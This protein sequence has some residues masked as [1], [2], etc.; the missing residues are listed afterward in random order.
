MKKLFIL[1]LGIAILLP[2]FV[3][4]DHDNTHTIQQLT[5]QLKVLQEKINALAGQTPVPSFS[6]PA[7]PGTLGVVPKKAVIP[8]IFD[9]DISDDEIIQLNNLRIQSISGDTL[10]LVI[11]ASHEFGVRCLRF[12]SPQA[13]KGA[14]IPCPI[15]PSVIYNIQVDTDTVLLLRNRRRARISDFKVGDRI[16]VYGFMDRDTNAVEALII[17]NLDKPSVRQFI[18]LNNVE[19][20]KGPS[21][22]NP[23]ATLIVAQRHPIPCLDFGESG[24]GRGAPFPCPLG[25]GGGTSLAPGETSIKG[26]AFSFQRKYEVRVDEATRILQGN[27]TTMPLSEIEIGDILN[28]YGT[29]TTDAGVINA[30]V[31]RDLSKP[32]VNTGILRV[33]VTA[34]DLQCVQ[35]LGKKSVEGLLFPIQCGIL[36]DASVFVEKDGILVARGT[37]EKGFMVFEGLSPGRYLIRASA[38]GYQEGAGEALIKGGGVHELTIALDKIIDRKISIQTPSDLTGKVGEFF[39]ALFFAEGGASPYSWKITAG[40]LPSGLALAPSSLR[41]Q[42]SVRENMIAIQGTPTVPGSYKFELTAVDNIGNQGSAIFVSIITEVQANRPPVIHGISGPI[43][44]KVGETGTWSIKASDPENHPLNYSV[45]WGDEMA[46]ARAQ[47]APQTFGI[48]QEATFT[49]VYSKSGT[50]TPRFIVTDA[51]GSSAEAS[52]TVVVEE[53]T[54]PSITVL[55]PNGGE[56]WRKETTQLIQWKA[57]PSILFVDIFLWSPVPPGSAAPS[58]GVFIATNV[59]NNGTYKWLV[60]RNTSQIEI[61]DGQYKIRISQSGT[62]NLDDSDAPFSITAP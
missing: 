26:E 54:V 37:T 20:L 35:E 30:I 14:S 42:E 46:A 5:E 21:S 3:L 52:I 45:V 11:T 6:T 38:P 57:D 10:P 13:Q 27:R 2:F 19:V 32:V 24:V 28:I 29:Y 50:Y 12:E 4:A 51:G 31:V 16:N 17:R 33:T 48:V 8:P 22:P 15:P 55:S 59:P 41:V 49:H 62:T 56:L 43:V 58:F 44:L 60:P 34:A 36:Y 53:V 23:P 61:P 7:T 1:H 40:S 25:S 39:R 47:S 9:E 18:Q